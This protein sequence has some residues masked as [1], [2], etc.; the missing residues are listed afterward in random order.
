MDLPWIYQ[1]FT[2]DLP[3]IYQGFTMD[4]PWIYHGFT[5]DSPEMYDGK[6][7]KGSFGIMMTHQWIQKVPHVQKMCQWI[8]LQ[9]SATKWSKWGGLGLQYRLPARIFFVQTGRVVPEASN[10]KSR[11]H[12][13][14]TECHLTNC[15]GSTLDPTK[16]NHWQLQNVLQIYVGRNFGW[17][18]PNYKMSLGKIMLAIPTFSYFLLQMHWIL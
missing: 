14:A 5:M 6:N 10:I 16:F 13:V 18:R 17:Q 15:T 3:W 7:I 9:I 8:H 1:G 4:L 12:F 11:L 2:M